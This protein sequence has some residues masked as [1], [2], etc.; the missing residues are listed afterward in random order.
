[1]KKKISHSLSQPTLTCDESTMGKARRVVCSNYISSKPTPLRN[2]AG[3]GDGPL[4]YA[5]GHKVGLKMGSTST[6]VS[7]DLDSTY[8]FEPPSR[9]QQAL[10]DG[11]DILHR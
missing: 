5:V 9:I 11:T 4:P 10:T 2:K 8:T 1:M 7:L 3:I 6:M